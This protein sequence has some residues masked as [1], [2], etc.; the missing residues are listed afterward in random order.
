MYGSG[1]QADQ[2]V[3]RAA[4]L[5]RVT[6]M[7]PVAEPEV[8][9]QGAAVHVLPSLSEGSPM[10]L[11]EAMA[12]GLAC[13]A[14]NCSAGVRDLVDP[15][16]NGLLV[17]TGDPEQLGTALDQV[18]SDEGLRRRLGSAARESVSDRKLAATLD[19]WEHLMDEVWR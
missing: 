6:V 13:V 16:V 17:R 11:V 19:R 1:P 4:E 14:T 12:T 7:Q 10:A 5:P 9:L 2:V 18:L 15:A 3:R 8:V